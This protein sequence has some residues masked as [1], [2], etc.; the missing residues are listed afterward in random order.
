MS[1]HITIDWLIRHHACEEQ[2]KIFEHQF[3]DGVLLT[4]ELLLDHSVTSRF[5][6]SWLA[7]HLPEIRGEAWFRYLDLNARARQEYI[8]PFGATYEYWP[9]C[10]EAIATIMFPAHEDNPN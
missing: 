1:R 4:K 10:A 7:Q 2:C 5:N 6:C 8:G 9:A 3:P